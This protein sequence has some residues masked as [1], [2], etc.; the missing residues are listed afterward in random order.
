M[1]AIM[2]MVN[3]EKEGHI[4]SKIMKARQLEEIR[5]ARRKEQEVRSDEKKAKFEETKDSL[6]KPRK[7]KRSSSVKT[8]GAEKEPTENTKPKK[9]RVSFG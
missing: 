8:D 9:K 1:M 6:R 4:E 2:S 7:H 3:A 5:E